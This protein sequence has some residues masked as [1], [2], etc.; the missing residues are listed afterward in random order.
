[1][2]SSAEEKGLKLKNSKFLKTV[3]TVGNRMVQPVTLFGILCII[4]VLLSF[5][6]SVLGWS[7]TGEMYNAQTKAVEESTVTVYNLLSRDGITYML[8]NFVNNTITYAPLGV[9]LVMFLGIGLADGSGL[10]AVAIRKIVKSAPE[11]LLIPIL[12]L[13]GVC[14]NLA[15]S[16]ATLV[17][18]PI[19]GVIYLNYGKHPIAGM[20]GILAAVTAGFSANLILTDTD[21]VMSAI[22][23][24][25]SHIMI[26][27]YTVT[28]MANYYFMFAGAI[29]LAITCTLVTEKIVEPMLGTYDPK[30]AGEDLSQTKLEDVSPVEE[31]AF[32]AAG[33]TLFA[34]L[35]ILV[36]LC[37]PSNSIFRNP[38]TGSLINGSLLMSAL[39]PILSLMFFIPSLVYGFKTGIFKGERDVVAQIYKSFGS[40]SS[41]FAIALTAGQFMKWFAKSNLGSILA[42]KGAALIGRLNIHY[43][44]LLLIF[45]I[46]TAFLN[47]FM[48]SG[49]AKWYIFA[50]VFVPMF[51][52][53]G[54]A[55]ELTQLMYRIGD[56]CTNSVT[57]LNS[58]LPVILLFM[59]KYKKDSGI[60]T[61]VATLLPYS[62]VFLIV[63]S[64]VAVI[65][66]LIGLP[67]GPGANLFV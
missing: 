11:K 46:I 8:N 55:P 22:T 33:L 54:I 47:I 32:K 45:V 51:I 10:I 14:G 9:M 57:P 25:A 48:N 34:M 18:V 23:Q 64:L 27:D 62:I 29:I 21:A 20:M 63:W 41:V 42:F 17:L 5:I 61:Y 43:I 2:S 67:I 39:I 31:K 52:Q 19:A 30:D 24:E 56:S 6:G 65:W 58:F 49:T 1:M 40:L 28:P 59:Q 13:V 15:S 60:G 66:L 26:P 36:V 35:A 50:P 12:M 4:V 37:I 44:V 16:S 3:E 38:D 7:A 53:L